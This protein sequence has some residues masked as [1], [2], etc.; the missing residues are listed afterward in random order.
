MDKMELCHISVEINSPRLYRFLKDII[1]IKT[2]KFTNTITRYNVILFKTVIPNNEYTFHYFC[3]FHN[4]KDIY[5]NNKNIQQ[6]VYDKLCYLH[7]VKY[8]SIR[9]KVETAVF[10]NINE[11]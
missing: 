5:A 9:R 10:Y 8:F 3:N 2:I 6:S 11:V 7:I 4:N 1:I